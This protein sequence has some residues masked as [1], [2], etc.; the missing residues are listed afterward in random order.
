MDRYWLQ[1]YPANVPHDIN[2]SEYASLRELIDQGCRE[3]ADKPA[4]TNMGTTLTFRELD[5]RS[6]ASAPGCNAKP[7]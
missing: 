3:H 2:P 4:Y 6:R 7:V 1:H 5:A